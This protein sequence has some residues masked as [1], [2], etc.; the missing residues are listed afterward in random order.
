MASITSCG[1]WAVAPL[2]KYTNGFPFTVLDRMGK[3]FRILCM[4][5]I[6]MFIYFRFSTTIEVTIY[7]NAFSNKPKILSC[8]DGISTLSINS[9]AKACNNNFRALSSPIPRA[10]K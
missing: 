3:S 1:F 10:F 5:N 4:S 8:K 2:S 6:V 9:C 7:Y